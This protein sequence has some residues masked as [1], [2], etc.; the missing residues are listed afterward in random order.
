[1]KLESVEAVYDISHQCP[2]LVVVDPRYVTPRDPVAV[3]VEDCNVGAVAGLGD[4]NESGIQVLQAGIPDTEH[5][6]R[7]GELCCNPLFGFLVHT[8]SLTPQRPLG[9]Y[10]LHSAW[11]SVSKL[12]PA[13]SHVTG[14]DVMPAFRERRGGA[15]GAVA[16]CRS[17]V[18]GCPQIKSET[19]STTRNK[20]EVPFGVGAMNNVNTP[21]CGDGDACT[22]IDHG[23]RRPDLLGIL[24]GAKDRCP[25]PVLSSRVF[26]REC[27][28]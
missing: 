21:P 4:R 12:T 24:T 5:G 22:P 16:T 25:V 3:G 6:H 8:L 23:Q 20:M 13:Q 18:S 11:K 10:H 1:V 27:R 15:T 17:K 9:Y 26:S 28:R 19:S 2:H 7:L 14:A